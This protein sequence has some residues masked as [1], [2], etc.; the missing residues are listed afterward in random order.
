MTGRLIL[1]CGIAGAGKTTLAKHREAHGAVR[2]CPDEWLTALGFDIYDK[3]ARAAIERLQWELAQSLLL[4]GLTVVDE[5]GVWRRSERDLRRAW[6]RAH[7]VA[8]EL[9]F[10]DA[11]VEEL[12][13]RVAHRNRPL[14]E[15]APRINPALVAF[16][17]TRI[18][19]PD[20]DELALFD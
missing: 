13:A 3:D 16:W 2:L 20:A 4:H 14:P 7:H 19:R 8:I 9:R 15:D 10:L 18:E 1:L 17:N 6:A 5:C 11:P 12:T